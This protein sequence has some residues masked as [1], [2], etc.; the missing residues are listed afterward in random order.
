MTREEIAARMKA[1]YPKQFR[2]HVDVL[3]EYVDVICDI[4]IEENGDAV[5]RM[6]DAY[7]AETGET[8]P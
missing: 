6:P 1:R 2:Q 4:L 3:L 8:K 5:P 7:Y